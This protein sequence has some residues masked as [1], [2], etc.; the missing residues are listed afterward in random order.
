MDSISLQVGVLTDEIT[1][2]VEEARAGNYRVL[3]SGH[4]VVV[5]WSPRRSPAVLKAVGGCLG[6]KYTSAVLKAMGGGEYN[7][8]P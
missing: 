7:T 5:G 1:S 8:I 3:E 4:T 6:A 2:R